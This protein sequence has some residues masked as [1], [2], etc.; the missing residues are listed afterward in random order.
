MQTSGSGYVMPYSVLD[1]YT[2]REL[3]LLNAAMLL[4]AELSKS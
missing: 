4:L 2:Q 3:I 1:E